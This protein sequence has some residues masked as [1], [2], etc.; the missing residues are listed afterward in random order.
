[1]ALTR[2]LVAT[3]HSETAQRAEEFAGKLAAPGQRLEIALLYVHPDLPLTAGRT[4]TV[5]VFRSMEHLDAHER[6]EMH[7]LLAQAAA[8][9]RDAAGTNEIAMSEDMVAASDIGAAI[10]HE[11]ERTNVEAIVMGS[12]GRSDFASL[13]LGSVSHKVLHLAHCPVI[14]VR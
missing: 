11:A 1:M 13:M 5:E 3:D 14:V 4:G 8:R 2:I 9:I 7:A 10:V 12:R 6:D